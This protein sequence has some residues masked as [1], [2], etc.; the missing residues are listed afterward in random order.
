MGQ[1]HETRR[2]ET[3]REPSRSGRPQTRATRSRSQQLPAVAVAHLEPEVNY[4]HMQ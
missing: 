4:A 1:T 2:D 3:R